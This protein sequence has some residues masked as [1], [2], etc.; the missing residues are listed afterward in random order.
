MQV[1]SS[2]TTSPPEPIIAPAFLSESKS[3]G[4]SRSSVVRHPPEGPPICTALNFFPPRTPPPMSKMTSLSVVPIGTSMSPVLTMLPVSA[5]AFV[6][7]LFSGPMDLYQSAP[8]VMISGT[9]AK[10]STLLSTVGLSN[11]PCSTVRGGFTRGMPRLPSMEAVSALPS[12]QT[13]APAPRAMC[14]VKQNSVPRMLS[15][16]SPSSSACAIARRSRLTASGYSAR[17]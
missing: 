3:S 14:S 8:R 1:S 11:R 4:R 6:P 16:S 7:G 13:N 9:L 10:V 15:P 17:T 5:K 12:P 2:M